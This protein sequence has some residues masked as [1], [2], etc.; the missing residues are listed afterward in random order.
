M[1]TDLFNKDGK[2]LTIDEIIDILSIKVLPTK[3]NR[4]EV[5]D[6]NGRSYVNWKSDNKIQIS[7]QD[8]GR[9]I[10]IFIYNLNI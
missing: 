8:N 5:I 3:A 10:K 1:K 4:I 2:E 9:T 6:P 7:V